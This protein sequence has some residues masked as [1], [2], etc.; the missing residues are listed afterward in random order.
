VEAPERPHEDLTDEEIRE[1]IIQLE[2]EYEEIT[3][4]P[5]IDRSA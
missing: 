3:G 2:K 4:S 5:L 1:R